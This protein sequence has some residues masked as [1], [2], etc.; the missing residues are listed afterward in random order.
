MSRRAAD[1]IDADARASAIRHLT[2]KPKK[3]QDYVQLKGRILDG[4]EEMQ[5]SFQRK[6]LRIEKIF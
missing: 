3:P 2:H 6:S 1:Y 5:R 4:V